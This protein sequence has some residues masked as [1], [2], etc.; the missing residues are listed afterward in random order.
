MKI[1]PPHRLKWEFELWRFLMLECLQLCCPVILVVCH[2][3]LRK[4]KLS[5]RW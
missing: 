5:K 4:G 2:L 1:I 3:K